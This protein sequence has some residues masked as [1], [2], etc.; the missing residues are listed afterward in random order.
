MNLSRRETQ[1]RSILVE[2]GVWKALTAILVIATVLRVLAII[3][4][5]GI[6]HPDEDF[7][8]FE[9]AH[10]FAFGYGVIPW[11][12]EEGIRSPLPPLAISV[13]F[14]LAGAFGDSPRFYI[15]IVRLVLVAVFAPQRHCALFHGAQ[16]QSFS[17]YNC[18]HCRSDLV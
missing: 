12:F 16:A 7:Q 8:M 17:R 5:P 6:H 4:F 15:A 9:Q 10:R 13:L 18:R 14:H 1:Q 2:Y 11:E 3:V